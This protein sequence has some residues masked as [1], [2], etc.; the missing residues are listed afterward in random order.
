MIRVL[1]F[2]IASI[3]IFAGATDEKVIIEDR[4]IRDDSLYR[5]T[6]GDSVDYLKEKDYE[7]DSRRDLLATSPK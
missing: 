7:I 2:S 5:S 6:E 4:I 3:F 1:I